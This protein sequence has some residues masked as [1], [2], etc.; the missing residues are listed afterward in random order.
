MTS[1]EQKGKQPLLAR[2][3]T[4]QRMLD[5]ERKNKVTN[6]GKEANKVTVTAEHWLTNLCRSIE[7][8]LRPQLLHQYS[9]NYEKVA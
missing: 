2:R 9:P 8:K 1:S 4:F 7:C 5:L 3:N 6:T